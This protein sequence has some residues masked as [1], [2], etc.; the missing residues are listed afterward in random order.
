MSELEERRLNLKRELVRRRLAE[1]QKA[2]IPA[3]VQFA[4]G[5]NET[6]AN[7]AGFPVDVANKA[8]G[9]VGLGVE[10][11]IGG[12]QQLTE[13]GREVGAIEPEGLPETGF[14]RAGQI[15]AASLPAFGAVGT[16]ARLGRTGGFFQPIV[17]SFRQAPRAFTAQEA[18]SVAGAA[19]LGEVGRAATGD[20]DAG[21]VIGE[22]MGGITAPAALAVAAKAPTL[23]IIREATRP[24]RKGASKQT[25]AQVVQGVVPDPGRTIVRSDDFQDIPGTAFT[26]GQKA[27]S[28]RLITLEKAVSRKVPELAEDMLQNEAQTNRALRS[29][30]NSFGERN[31]GQTRITA[32]QEFFEGQKARVKNALNARMA[33]AVKSMRERIDALKPD[34]TRSDI[35]RLINDELEDALKDARGQEKAIW[36]SLDET[37]EMALRNVKDAA[38]E[39]IGDQ[40]PIPDFVRNFLDFDDVKVDNFKNIKEFRTKLLRAQRFARANGQADTA[41]FL[42]RINDGLL[43][44][45]NASALSDDFGVA[46]DF[47]RE[48]NNR[49]TRGRVGEAL[50]FAP[51]GGRAIEPER[52]SETLFPTGSPVRATEGLRATRQA[53]SAMPGVESPVRQSEIEDNVARL[54]RTRIFKGTGEFDKAAAK[55]LVERKDEFLS[56]FPDLK[57][58]VQAALD[59]EANVSQLERRVKTAQKTLKDSR[60]SALGLVLNAGDRVDDI[61]PN[62]LNSPN[63]KRL[64]AQAARNTRKDRQAFKGLQDGYVDELFNRG[65][66]GQADVNGD[67]ILSGARLREFFKTTVQDVKNS[68][69]F[70]AEEL[71]R[72][73]T[74]I[75]NAELLEQVGTSQKIAERALA[76]NTNLLEDF[77]VRAMGANLGARF[78]GQNIGAGS[79]VSAE[80]GSKVARRIVEKLPQE[81]TIEILAEAVKDETLMKELL[82]LPLTPALK[83][84]GLARLHA[85]MA[86]LGIEVPDLVEDIQESE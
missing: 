33:G 30:L 80:A 55:S 40:T 63:R 14:Q 8:L 17:E 76:D 37:A 67:R 84:K 46:V 1:R 39:F 73:D 62:I 43:D 60:K 12:S 78:A 53:V 13:L 16:A 85:W 58:Q 57:R 68:G 41:F 5:F 9:L 23:N 45:I 81:K 44:D 59:D 38:D 36:E 51:K 75:K 69:L 70:K 31:P 79:L 2:A 34:S 32:T 29:A 21:Q 42:Q 15:T 82:R 28:D 19:T 3:P 61:V 83:Q 26:L 54:I 20:S 4:G 66:S 72:L 24:F 56:Q 6:L 50:R 48:L 10:R 64:L 27:G 65:L 25:A 7:I 86:G 74:I 47:S 18:A 49:F 77:L 52:V 35:S 22:I 71:K 11:P